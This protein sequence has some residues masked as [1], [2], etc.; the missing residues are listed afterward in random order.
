MSSGWT[1]QEV[2]NKID[3]EG[4][5]VETLMWGLSS[6]DIADDLLARAWKELEDLNLRAV[7]ARIEILLPEPGED[8]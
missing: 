6:K 3:H 5:L 4:G 8:E 1:K 2:A 7:F